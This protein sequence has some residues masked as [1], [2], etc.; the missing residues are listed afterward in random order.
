VEV[1]NDVESPIIV[2]GISDGIF[3]FDASAIGKL[4]RC[5]M[6]NATFP[7][8][9]LVYEV[10]LQD[11]PP[12]GIESITN[13]KLKITIVD[14]E[15]YIENYEGNGTVQ[16][17]DVAGRTVGARFIAPINNDAQTINISHLPSGVYIVRVGNQGAKFVKR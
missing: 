15:L 17:F 1:D 3:T 14:D 8:L 16:I 10:L 13:D 2:N 11:K 4:V 7:D 12:T 5:K 9:T 6:T